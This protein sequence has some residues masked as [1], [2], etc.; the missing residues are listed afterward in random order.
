MGSI[1]NKSRCKIV[2]LLLFYGL[3]LFAEDTKQIQVEKTGNKLIVSNQL[4]SRTISF[5]E[6]EPG[7]I[8]NASFYLKQGEQEIL[9]SNANNEWFKVSINNKTISNTDKYWKYKNNTVREMQNNGKEIKLFF[10]GEEESVK[11]L[12]I[13]YMMQIFNNSTIVRERIEFSTTANDIYQ[14]TFVE[15]KP[16]FIFPLYNIRSD[17]PGIDK[18]TLEIR[19]AS[20]NADLIEL[21]DKSSFDY[22]NLEKDWRIGRNLADNYMYHPKKILCAISDG[23]TKKYKGPFLISQV[24]GF[25]ANLLFAYEHGSPDDDPEQEYIF[26]QQSG[27]D[28]NISISSV[29]NSGVY[30]KNESL[31]IGKS[32]SSVWNVIGF[33]EGDYVNVGENI[34]WDYL[35]D[36]I[37]EVGIS[38]KSLFYYNTWGMQRDESRRGHDIRGVLTE[39][40]VIREID[41]ASQL[42]IDLFVLDD[43]WQD[44][45]GDWNPDKQRY[46]NGL[47]F[48]IDKCEEKNIIPGIWLATLATDS[49]AAITL[50]H[51]EWLIRETNSKPVI[52]RWEKNVF[53]FVSDYK[54]YFVQKSKSLID[55]G[56]RYF[57]WDGMDKHLCD[58]PNHHHGGAKQSADERKLKQGYLLPLYITEA[59]K[60]LKEYNPDIIVEVDVTE[61]ERSVGLAIL[62][63]ARYFW[64]NNGASWYGDYSS[65]RTKS[66]RM[67]PN[68]FGSFMPLTLMTYANFPMNDPTYTSQHYNVNSS[69]IGGKGLWGN[70]ARMKPEERL[71]VGKMV[72]KLKL[73]EEEITGV[74]PIITGR[75]GSSPE[76]YEFVDKIKS[77]GKVISFSGSALKKDYVVKDINIRNLLGVLNNSYLTAENKL[78]IQ[79][80]YRMPDDTKEAFVLTN[81][82]QGIGIVSSTS[83]LEMVELKDANTMAFTNGAPGEHIVLW[84]KEKGKP[85]IDSNKPIVVLISEPDN[86]SY[87]EIEIKTEKSLTHI[88]LSSESLE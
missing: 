36:K 39:E 27:S 45:F 7:E 38:R 70:I 71:L 25:N 34:I 4:I 80:E 63:E 56:I 72:S 15:N 26:I 55:D 62:S 57:K 20:W 86:S 2:L 40:K 37:C 47:K 19:I 32:L 8:T 75:V 82:G 74:K 17:S 29:Y 3:S 11:H 12:E 35:Y 21:G 77:V 60:E 10:I 84:T 9:N 28:D 68:L 79:F 50:A 41:D 76:V 48:Y 61:A 33:F 66:M 59:I 49:T 53:C 1:S 13:V 5:S 67:I 42:G 44:K 87:Y 58:S 24:A 73:V 83:W 65:Y 54:N 64:M 22:R 46:E 23:E 52:G 16:C 81:D 30:Y 6:N 69:F 43:G 14:L 18:N 31:K 78:N 51:P 85:S 88:I